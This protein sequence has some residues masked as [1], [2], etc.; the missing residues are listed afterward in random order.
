MH[1][2]EGKDKGEECYE[3]KEVEIL[4]KKSGEERIK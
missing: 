4:K 1:E 2:K 3:E